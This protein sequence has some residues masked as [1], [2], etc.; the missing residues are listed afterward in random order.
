MHFDLCPEIRHDGKDWRFMGIMSKNREEWATTQIA[1]YHMDI[2]QVTFYDTLGPEATEYILKQTQLTTI[3]ISADYLSMFTKI[4]REH[5]SEA[6]KNLVV[7]PV[8]DF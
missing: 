6:L 1:N 8:T 4:K 5:K 2:T 7:W 3:S